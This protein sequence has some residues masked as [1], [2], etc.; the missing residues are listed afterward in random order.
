MASNLPINLKTYEASPD[1]LVAETALLASAVLSLEG[2][3]D[4]ALIQNADA[5]VQSI[6]PYA[7]SRH[8]GVACMAH[9]GL[10]K[11]YRAAHLI[12]QR[13]G[14]PDAKFQRLLEISSASALISCRERLPHRKLEQAWLAY[15]GGAPVW[16]PQLIA[17]TA[18]AHPQDVLF[19]SRDDVYAFTHALM[20][21]TDFGR[22][23][24]PSEIS[25]DDLCM[26]ADAAL[27]AAMDCDDFDLAGELLMTWP[28]TGRPFSDRAAFCFQVLCVIEDEVGILPSFSLD[29]REFRELPVNARDHHKSAAGY[30]TVYVMGL[31]SAL[32]LKSGHDWQFSTLVGDNQTSCVDVGET[33]KEPE[34]ATIYS[35]MDNYAKSLVRSLVADANLIRAARKMNLNTLH[36][37]LSDTAGN[38][39]ATLVQLQCAELLKR[40]S[41]DALT[42]V[43][44]R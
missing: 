39:A 8:I 32:L 6:L 4:D 10:T 14:Y 34:W 37:A 2:K 5:L 11:D 44:Q 1:K 22:L 9:P 35:R 30:H 7:R 40:M 28:L 19:S 41:S 3:V 20:Y 27:V 15:L 13:T 31:L 25:T 42:D 43:L 18:L 26:T 33:G 12:L 21:A 24:L 16:S 36:A 38:G 23:P 17:E 29:G